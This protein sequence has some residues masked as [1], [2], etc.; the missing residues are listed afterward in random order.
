[1][2]GDLAMKATL[3]DRV[4]AESDDIVT[5]GGYAYFPSTAVHMAWLEKAE[6]TESDHACPHGV[7]FYDVVIDGERHA[8]AAWSYEAPRP[9]MQ[10]VGGRFGFWEDV[11]VE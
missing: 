11:K 4:V 9:T 8:R 7:Q 2:Q 10:A 3:N 5:N 1:M 6:K